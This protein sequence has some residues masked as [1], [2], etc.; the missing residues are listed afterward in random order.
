[1]ANRA[2][3]N[4]RPRKLDNEIYVCPVNTKPLWDKVWAAARAQDW[5]EDDVGLVGNHQGFH[6]F[7]INGLTTGFARV[8]V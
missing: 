8:A 1:M 5:Y 6:Y 7:Q 3:F 2:A 4:H